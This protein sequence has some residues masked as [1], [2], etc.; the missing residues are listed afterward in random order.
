[1]ETRLIIHQEAES[2]QDL[3]KAMALAGEPE[4][5]AVMAL[6]QT[7]GRGRSGHTWISPAGKNLALSF[8]LRPRIPPDEIP[9]LGLMAA[10]AVSETVEPQGISRA[11]LK[12]PNDVIVAGKK[13]A[14]ILPEAGM[15]GNS[16]SY[17]II[18]VG[19]NVNSEISDFPPDLQDS[20]TSLFICASRQWNLMD[21]AKELLKRM[22]HLYNRA[23]EEGPG[24]IPDL[25]S[26]RW[27]HL[28]R[29][30]TYNGVIGVGHGI[31]ADGSLILRTH[32]DQLLRVTSGIMDPI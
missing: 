24:F 30:F 6:K 20:V 27:A 1:M 14:G 22:D 23:H 13:L 8:L 26:K 16:V 3:V 5:V 9:L 17:V 21:T 15:I 19:L 28:G 18:G 2:T 7:S 11:E 31:S 32:E 25:W 29:T 12:W 10:I 4:G